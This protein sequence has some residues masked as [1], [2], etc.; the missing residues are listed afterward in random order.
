MIESPPRPA[1]SDTD[2]VE[3]LL[4]RL[5]EVTEE[6]RRVQCELAQV[7]A[8]QRDAD[9]R[10]SIFDEMLPLTDILMR[11]FGEPQWPRIIHGAD[12]THFT[13]AL[14]IE[15]RARGYEPREYRS[16]AEAFLNDVILAH[17]GM[18]SDLREDAAYAFAAGFECEAV[19]GPGD[20][21]WLQRETTP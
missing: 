21:W 4:E 10:L 15:L 12:L 1:P 2:E 11:A 19:R 17:P 14:L 9:A 13:N 5:A 16:L 7:V 3:R 8:R 18:R 6:A 20:R